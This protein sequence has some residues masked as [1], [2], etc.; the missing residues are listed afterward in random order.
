M[1]RFASLLVLCAVFPLLLFAL[2]GCWRGKPKER[3]APVVTAVAQKKDA[4]YV[5]STVGTIKASVSV[6]I[7]SKYA[8]HIKKVH[9]AE[10]SLVKAGQLLFTIDPA[11]NALSEQQAGATHLRDKADYEQLERDRQRYKTLADQGVISRES[12]EEKSTAAIRARNAM[13]ASAAGAS[14]ARQ[15]LA[16]NTITSPID[17]RIGAALFDEGSF[18]KDKDDILAVVNT[19]TPLEVSFALP[20][21]YLNEIRKQLAQGPLTVQAAAPGMERHPEVGVLTFV[22]NQVESGTGTVRM[23]ARFENPEGRLWPGQF[24]NVGLVLKTVKDAV[25][26]PVRAVQNGP[27]GTYVFVIKDGKAEMV[28][29]TVGFRVYDALVIESGLSGGETVVVEGH[30]RLVPG[31]LVAATPQQEPVVPPA[32]APSGPAAPPAAN[33]TEAAANA[34]RPE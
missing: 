11:V 17:G 13:K 25:M 15:N 23:K 4:P 29:V 5:L 18:V 32:P 31:A 12:Y 30:L 34:T 2:P 7:K 10:G 8:A 24:V 28:P 27:Q 16:Y 26:V 14:L 9:F 33:A 22:D 6:N 20:E 1:R 3:P 19:T 21:R